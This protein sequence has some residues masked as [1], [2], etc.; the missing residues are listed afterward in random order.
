MKF[1]SNII[2]LVLAVAFSLGATFAQNDDQ[3]LT[4]LQMWNFR[5]TGSISIP[6]MILRNHK[7]MTYFFEKKKLEGGGRVFLGCHMNAI[8]YIFLTM[9]E[10]RIQD[11]WRFIDTRINILVHMQFILA[12]FQSTDRVFFLVPKDWPT[13]KI[14]EDIS[15]YFCG[16]WIVARPAQKDFVSLGADGPVAMSLEQWKESFSQEWGKIIEGEVD[17][18]TITTKG[19]NQEEAARLGMEL[20]LNEPTTW[21]LY[22][23]VVKEDRS[24]SPGGTISSVLQVANEN[25]EWDDLCDQLNLVE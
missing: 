16:L 23:S 19:L 2:V 25:I 11:I 5:P 9:P 17:P 10:E 18:N 21:K 12:L 7:V 22:Q 24:A 1:F 4:Q 14:V 13:Y 3:V 15:K 20:R 8:A 6:M